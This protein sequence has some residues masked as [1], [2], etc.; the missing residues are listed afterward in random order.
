M[1]LLQMTYIMEVE[2]C[3]SMNR[4]ARNLFVS[5][6]ALSAAIAEVERELGITVFR[7][8]N[9]GI[10]LTQE[11]QEL[12]AQITPLVEGSRQL[13][14]YYSRRR[15]EDRVTLSV[16][17]Q[18]YPFC[19]K[20]FVE[21]LHLLEEPQIQVSF[22]EMEM[23][24][25]ID[26]VAR[27]RSAIGILFLSEAT[28]H[29]ITRLLREKGLTFQPLMNLRPRVFLRKGHPLSS[30]KS[31]KLEQLYDYPYVVFTQS[32]NNYHFAE[33]AVAGTA[34]SFDRV[35]TVSDRATAYN[36]IAHTDSVSTGSG[37][38]PEG[39]GDDRLT[40]LPL[41]EAVPE[42]RLG[43]IQLRGVPLPATAQP[44]IDILQRLL[45][46]LNGAEQQGD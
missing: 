13:K 12:I 17:S 34:S 31:V 26:E 39:Y 8:S 10:D 3:G 44:F 19:A 29:F 27:R 28:E 36:V 33:E 24:A 25:V 46:E 5:Q 9:R 11:G 20:A 7:R 37:V 42:M 41:D 35:I 1:T 38:L 32:D 4:A 22:K 6:S 21:Y 16:A 14:R 2:R 30:Q 40:T 45:R 15:A 18:R 43:Y 23:A